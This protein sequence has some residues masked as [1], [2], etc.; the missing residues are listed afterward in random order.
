MTASK[1]KNL[2]ASVRQ[3][4]RNLVADGA[5]FNRTLRQYAFE[6]LLYRILHVAPD[7]QFILKGG[8]L[9]TVWEGQQR[10]PTRD[11]DLLSADRGSPTT[12]A[13]LFR[14]VCVANVEP[15]GLEFDR[16]SVVTKAILEG[17]DYKAVRILASASLEQAK[18]P[19][20][21][22][23]GFG[24]IVTPAPAVSLVPP[25]LAFPPVR[26]KAYPPE[27]AVAEKVDAMVKLKS[28][29]TRMKDFYDV[30]MLSATREFD[31]SLLR[32]ALMA[33]FANRKTPMPTTTPFALTPAF[34]E[35][36]VK[37]S[38]WQ[39]FL[40]RNGLN[41]APPNLSEVIDLLTDFLV[42]VLLGACDQR[43]WL[44]DRGWSDSPEATM[45]APQHQN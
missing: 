31:G 17:H 22:D 14:S 23:V 32:R 29:N 16:R 41:D 10:R 40:T 36:P 9:W 26:I 6:R 44:P 11:V 24:D 35:D 3:R 25:L 21:V 8:M 19:I 7:D 20:Q 2:P 38:Q 43:T 5:E 12:F 34:A 27:T 39:A 45:P 1:P 37:R 33:T 13:K 30:L 18:I 28:S 15:D 42:P 4:L